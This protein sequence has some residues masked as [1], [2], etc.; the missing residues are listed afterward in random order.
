MRKR[1]DYNKDDYQQSLVCSIL[2]IYT[3][4]PARIRISGI[5]KFRSMLSDSRM[6]LI[7]LRINDNSGEIVGY[8]KGGPLENYQLRRGTHDG[9]LGKNNTAYMEYMS[10]K[11][12]YW[13]AYRRSS[14]KE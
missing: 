12:G 4:L 1:I 7:T 2:D 13:G 3:Q 10:I 8:A 11:P 14:S 9:N 6:I 5:E